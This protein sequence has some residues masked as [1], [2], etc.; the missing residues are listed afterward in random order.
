MRIAIKGAPLKGNNIRVSGTVIVCHEMTEQI[1]LE[2]QLVKYKM[3]KQGMMQ[4]LL[5][6][7]IRITKTD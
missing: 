2:E 4:S 6:G 7:K 3:M 1:K 5:T